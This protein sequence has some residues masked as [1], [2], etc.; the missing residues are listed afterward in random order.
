MVGRRWD[1]VA[2]GSDDKLVLGLLK[3]A[4]GSLL[5]HAYLPFLVVP[6]INILYSF[7]AS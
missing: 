2:A 1:F 6:H 4:L 3:L 5:E 7:I